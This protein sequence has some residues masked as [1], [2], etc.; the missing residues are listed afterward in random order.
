MRGLALSNCDQIR[1]VHNSFV[2]PESLFTDPDDRRRRVAGEDDDLFHFIS[3]V[4][5]NG[6]L[7]ELDGLRSGPIDHGKTEDWLEDVGAV[8]QKR[9][10][11]YS[12]G[13]IRFN[14][15]AVIGDRR[16]LLNEQISTVDADLRRLREK[17]E[18]LK[19]DDAADSDEVS[20]DVTM[21]IAGLSSERKELEH[22]VDIEND[23]FSRYKFDNSL[24]KLN[25]IPFVY[26]LVRAMAQ[27]GVLAPAIENAKEKA[28]NRSLNQHQWQ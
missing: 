21:R 20:R 13:E 19:L 4:P 25:F 8:I 10:A 2:R 12:Q 1:E 26:Q 9:M 14:L 3:Y 24:R 16:K 27:K 6:R 5:V 23:K 15:M 22:M 28:K 17:L 11:E 7:Y 18:A